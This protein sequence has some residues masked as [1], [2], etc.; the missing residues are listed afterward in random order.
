MVSSGGGGGSK[1][2]NMPT[3]SGGQVPYGETSPAMGTPGAY[4]VLPGSANHADDARRH[5]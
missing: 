2:P 3:P 1:A 5:E 4:N